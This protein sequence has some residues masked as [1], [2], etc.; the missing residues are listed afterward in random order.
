MASLFKQKKSAFWWIK[1]LDSTTGKITRKSTKLTDFTKANRL[2][3]EYIAKENQFAAL[4]PNEAWD[5]WV[6]GFINQRY[7]ENKQRPQSTWRNL[8][9]FLHENKLLHP[10]QIT[11][12]H[13]TAYLE[14]RA[15]PN[16]TQ[17]KF[18]AGRNTALLEISQ[19]CVF[20]D[21]AVNRGFILFNPWLKLR[22]RP[23]S[24]R[25]KPEY[26]RTALAR[27]LTAIRHEPPRWRRFLLY[28]FLIARYHGCRLRE[29]H[30]N[31]MTQVAFS[32][33]HLTITFHAKGHRD[34][35]VFL[36]KKLHRR[37]RKMCD[38]GRTET[39]SM[40]SSP[41]WVWFDFLTR[42]GIKRD[43]P[44]AC[45]H[46]F[47]VTAATTLARMGVAEKKAMDYIGHATTTIHRS[48][49]RLKPAD[50]EVCADALD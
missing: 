5:G 10:R 8:R 12:A 19:M 35:T 14:W 25:L 38:E 36:H 39:Y 16:K 1:Y 4:C 27:I 41:T 26:T 7:Q 32:G 44:G 42:I 23:A 13:A 45:F 37:F 21:E 40:P 28:S 24:H 29:T 30:L 47:R 15:T 22:L 2:L 34:H 46:S 17:R 9:M 43:F 20:L 48:Y 49:V 6:E 50:L 33:P 3:S 18:T 31:P 11:R